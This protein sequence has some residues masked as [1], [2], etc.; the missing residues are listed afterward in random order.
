MAHKSLKTQR[1]SDSITHHIEELILQGIVKPGERLPSERELAQQLEVSRSSLRDALIRLEARGLLQVRPGGGAYVCDLLAPTLTEPLVQLLKDKP[2]AL[3]DLLELR[4][5]L[6]EFA[7]YYA[8]ERCTESDHKILARQCTEVEHAHQQGDNFRTAIAIADFHLSVV[9]A[10]HNVAL[11]LV[12]RGLFN[13]MRTSVS[14]SLEKI[15]TQPERYQAI[16]KLRMAMYE[17]ITARKPEA[18]RTAAHNLILYVNKTLRE[19]DGGIL[20]TPSQSD[21][22][23]APISAAN[24][25]P[26]KMSDGIVER[27]ENLIAD[28]MLQA[29]DRLPSEETLAD[30]FQVSRTVVREAIVKLEARGL[31][32]VKRSGGIFI[33]DSTGSTVTDPLVHLLSERPEAMFDFLELRRSLDELAA[34]YAASRSTEAD[35]RNISECFTKLEECYRQQDYFNEVEYDAEFHLSIAEASH[36]VVLLYVMKGLFNLLRKNVQKNLE[37]LRSSPEDHRV[38]SKHHRDI[39]NA[40]LNGEAEQARQAAHIHVVFVDQSLRELGFEEVREARSQRRLEFLSK[41]GRADA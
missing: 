33:L 17:S 21:N 18:A 13:I 36:N 34:Y 38:V 2:K 11:M 5:A 6:E 30:N 32:R 8:A 35:K 20:D 15:Y 4:S 40:I 31:L 9:D 27:F 41:Q 37:R 26:S 22:L 10:T 16:H 39:L 28:A 19:L 24:L 12:T 7:A 1:I 29:G 3:L 14:R 25:K 23:F